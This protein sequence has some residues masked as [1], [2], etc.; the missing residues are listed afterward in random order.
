LVAY[1]LNRLRATPD[2]DG[3]LLDHVAILYGAG[4]ADSNLH[5]PANLPVLI[6][7]GAGGRI[8]AGR[9]VKYE[10]GT[11]IANLHLSLLDMFG[12]PTVER[13]GDSTGRLSEL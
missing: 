6:A 13:L 2:G 12:V 9:H 1:D 5:A 3:T 8:K 10:A 11:P 4:M 7:G